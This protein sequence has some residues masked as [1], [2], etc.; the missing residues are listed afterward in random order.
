[1]YCLELA[2]DLALNLSMEITFV[3][4]HCAS[5]SH[6]LQITITN[7]ASSNKHNTS[8]INTNFLTMKWNELIKDSAWVVEDLLTKEECEYLLRRANDL[9]IL[10]QQSPGDKKHRNSTTVAFDDEELSNKLFR[11]MKTLLPQEVRVDENCNNLGLQASKEQLYGRWTPVG[12]NMRWRIACYP[13]AGHF[14][15]HRDAS[16]VA[17]EHH[18]SLLTINGFL[19]DRPTGYGGATRF[20]KDDINAS[21]DD[22]GIFSAR[23]SDVLHRVEAERSGTASVFLHDLMHDG[24]PLREGSPPKWLFRADVMYARDPASIPVMSQDQEEA[25][26]YLAR[27]EELEAKG[28]IVGAI[29]FYKKA[30]RLDPELE[31]AR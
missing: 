22:E 21:L 29:V 11:R 28:D 17:N 31:V 16:Y 13:G 25:R 18:R 5:Y 6:L 4:H 15:P 2:L 20:L 8:G 24:E 26:R 19:T 1:M 9:D 3:L 23:E 14:G 7:N 27:A 30:Y 12:I 10:S